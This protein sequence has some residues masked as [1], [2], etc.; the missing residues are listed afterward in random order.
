MK[1]Q[2]N[3]KPNA[4]QH[5]EKISAN[6]DND[7]CNT[8]HRCSRLKIEEVRENTLLSKIYGSNQSF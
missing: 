5:N 1:Q 7:K 6:Q 3:G 2:Q 8:W 4:W